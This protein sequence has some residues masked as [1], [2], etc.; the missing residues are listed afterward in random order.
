MLF[1]HCYWMQ[2]PP[3][4]LIKLALHCKSPVW[5]N[6]DGC[7]GTFLQNCTHVVWQIIFAPALCFR[8]CML[9]SRLNLLYICFI[10]RYILLLQLCTGSF[11]TY[12]TNLKRVKFLLPA[13]KMETFW[14]VWFYQNPLHNSHSSTQWSK[15]KIRAIAH[16]LKSTIDTMFYRKWLMT[17]TIHHRLNLRNG[18]ARALNSVLVP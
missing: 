7:E 17:L 2:C 12:S 13:K 8:T 1:K 6:H 3:I 16:C 11:C 15:L 10:G 14:M 5:M 9:G 18:L 4:V